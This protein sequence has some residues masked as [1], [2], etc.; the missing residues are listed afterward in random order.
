MGRFGTC[1]ERESRSPQ[2]PWAQPLAPEGGDA[3]YGLLPEA[4]TRTRLSWAPSHRPARVAQLSDEGV[5]EADPGWA[6]R[7]PQF[8]RFAAATEADP[9]SH[10]QLFPRSRRRISTADPFNSSPRI[11]WLAIG[12]WALLCV[13]LFVSLLVRPDRVS[14]QLEQIQPRALITA[15]RPMPTTRTFPPAHGQEV[16][17]TA[18]A[19]APDLDARPADQGTRA[20]L[21]ADLP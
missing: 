8:P 2:V 12:G 3:A 1:Q 4:P 6:T 11:R 7:G 16:T 15:V 17:S 20:G 5:S 10:D 14:F 19:T 13:A 18:P 9:P 21:K